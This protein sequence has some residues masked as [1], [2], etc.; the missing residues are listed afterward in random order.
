MT[1]IDEAVDIREGEELDTAAVD[2]FMK[3]AIPDLQG[4]PEIRQ[5]PGGAARAESSGKL[6]TGTC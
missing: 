4:E 1:Q 2:R 3:E 6:E 5:Y